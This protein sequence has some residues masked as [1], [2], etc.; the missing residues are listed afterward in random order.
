MIDGDLTFLAFKDD[1]L[2]GVPFRRHGNDSCCLWAGSCGAGMRSP[3]SQAA[4]RCA[5]QTT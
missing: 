2:D 5:M 4:A 1:F 3:L